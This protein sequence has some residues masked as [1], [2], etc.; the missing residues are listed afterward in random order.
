MVNIMVQWLATATLAIM[1]PFFVS[2]IQIDHNPKEASA[3]ISVRIFTDDLE[4]TLQKYTTAKID[5]VHP[6]D[7]NLINQQLSS[8]IGKYLRLKINGQIV[9]AKYIG[10]EIIKESTWSYFEIAGIK[11]MNQLQIDCALLYDFENNQ[12]N[13]IHA[14]S[15]GTEKSYKLDFPNRVTNFSF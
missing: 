9:I 12:I 15:K 1:H 2:V 6:K 3:E 7:R 10:Y 11:E 8:Y 4:K 14:K 5:I 13:I